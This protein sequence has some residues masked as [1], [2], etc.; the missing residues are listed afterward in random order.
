M[1]RFQLSRKNVL[2]FDIPVRDAVN[3]AVGHG[4]EQLPGEAH[5]PLLQRIFLAWVSSL[6]GEGAVAK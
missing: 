1:I 2:G 3:V 6:S 5:H 4:I